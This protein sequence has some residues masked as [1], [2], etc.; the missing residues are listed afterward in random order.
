MSGIETTI[1][2]PENV[3]MIVGR[4]KCRVISWS[5][6]IRRR[7][8]KFDDTENFQCVDIRRGDQCSEA[9]CPLYLAYLIS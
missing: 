4:G 1:K 5:F 7:R 9:N 8:D 6:D 2:L 3:R